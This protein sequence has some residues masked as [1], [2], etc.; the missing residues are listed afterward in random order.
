MATT[1]QASA[2][3]VPTVSTA[4]FKPL[5]LDEIM[6]VPLA[7]QGAHDQLVMDMDEL[8][9]MTSNAIGK[10]KDYVNA[11]KAAY[12]GEIAGIRD[13]LMEG[14]VDRGMINKFKTLRSKKNL[15]FSANGTTGKANAAYN[16][17][18]LNKKALMARKDLD[19]DTKQLGLAEAQRLYEEAG[20][21]LSGA[22]YEDFYGVGTVDYMAEAQKIG[23]QMNPQQIAS[24][25]GLTYDER[26]GAY[27]DGNNSTV[28]LTPEQIQRVTYDTLKANVDTMAY[29]SEQE[30]LGRIP[31]AEQAIKDAAIAAGNIYQKN[32]SKLTES[33]PSWA[34]SAGGGGGTSMSGQ[35]WDSV[36]NVEGEAV[37]DVQTGVDDE[38]IANVGFMEDGSIN[39]QS[40][41]PEDLQPT[42]EEL[43][44]MSM[45]R[46]QTTLFSKKRWLVDHEDSYNAGMDIAKMRRDFPLMQG[47]NPATG[48]AYTDKEIYQTSVDAKKKMA[49]SASQIYLPR[50]LQNSYTINKKDMLRLDGN[51]D[52]NGSYIDSHLSINGYEGDIKKVAKEM[53]MTYEDLTKAIR[54]TGRLRGIAVGHPTMPGS[55]AFGITVDGEQITMYVASTN[56]VSDS[57]SRV[58]NMN[59]A[60]MDGERFVEGSR[61]NNASGT[62][63]HI[64]TELNPYTNELD[65]FQIESPRKI[66]HAEY[67]DLKWVK[68]N[69]PAVIFAIDAQGKKHYKKT[70]REIEQYTVQNVMNSWDSTIQAKTPH[71]SLKR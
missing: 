63:A 66:T 62:Y 34:N 47:I 38:A 48:K 24:P 61:M 67:R 70:K 55:D 35:Y 17:M 60:L 41:M 46:R 54:E 69:N 50:N 20:G 1:Q 4:S 19:E 6:M 8:N 45:A 30:R 42:D 9:L 11:Q 44:G 71:S 18:Q 7:K 3:I 26:T 14:G 31:S 28:I 56:K 39:P 33:Y 27:K 2:S 40:I 51:I 65:Q 64:A 16:Q 68:Q 32:N 13:R 52:T 21:A 22:Q 59:K 58:S 29:L 37:F 5:S 36:F 43:K 10:D 12:E 53:K 15:E 25:L 49:Q 23:A 57:F